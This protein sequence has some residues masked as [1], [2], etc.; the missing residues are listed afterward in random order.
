MTAWLKENS[1]INSDK[2]NER[3]SRERQRRRRQYAIMYINASIS[4]S[5]FFFSSCRATQ[6][7]H[8]SGFF[9]L[10]LFVLESFSNFAFPRPGDPWELNRLPRHV[11]AVD[12]R[13]FYEPA[14]YGNEPVSRCT[15]IGSRHFATR[16]S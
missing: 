1:Q 14:N 15:E 9:G 4:A 2:R 8:Y 7:A 5:F 16:R 10:L 6:F 11:V 3:E 12:F 13:L